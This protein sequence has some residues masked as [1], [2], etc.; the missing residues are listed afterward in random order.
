MIIKNSYRFWLVLV[1]CLGATGLQAQNLALARHYLK[2]AQY[3]KALAIY[4]DWYDNQGY[5]PEVYRGLLKIYLQK[6]RFDDAEKL[7]KD[8]SGRYAVPEAEV[9]LFYVYQKA[10]KT[11]AARQ[12]W[13][14]IIEKVK[15]Q[16]AYALIYARRLRAYGYTD[17]A[18]QLLRNE[19]KRKPSPGLYLEMGNLY[20]EKFLPD[21]MMRAYVRAA[22]MH[23]GYAS[24]IQSALSRY[25]DAKPDNPYAVALK[26]VLLEKIAQNPA[27]AYFQLLLWLYTRQQQYD[28]AFVQAKGLYLRGLLRPVDLYHLA[29][30]ARRQGDNSTALTIVDF[31][32]QSKEKIPRLLAEQLQVL[33]A[34]I[35][36]G[37][38]GR[39]NLDDFVGRWKAVADTLQYDQT[40]F[41]LYRLLS[42]LLIENE[43][44]DTAYHWADSLAKTQAPIRQQAFWQ[45][46]KG[47][48]L[49][50][51]GQFA[52]AA[53]VFTLLRE[54]FRYDEVNYRAL[55]KMALASFL[56]G[57]ADWAHRN[58]KP[59]KKAA[60]R[61]IANDALM[62]DFMI[63]ANR[64]PADSLQ[65]GLQNLAQ[66]YYYYYTGKRSAL[67]RTA[68]SLRGLA[69]SKK[70]A[71]DLLYLEAKAETQ[72]GNTSA[73]INYWEKLLS[74]TKEKMFRQE[75]LYR[76]GILLRDAGQT[77]K[78][79]KILLEVIRDY[80]E[81]FYFEPAQKAYRELT[82]Q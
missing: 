71:D 36:S 20:A 53:I 77:E 13:K 49:L 33:R 10:G 35:L 47:D 8:A 80:P 31:L 52:R 68:D 26:R 37:K 11:D 3:D 51:Q 73:A 23:T 48:V 17:K 5:R 24:Y 57:D 58:L 2:A 6:G 29:L 70:I 46:R 18:L 45:E 55:Y 82:G 25:I 38:T 74:T 1:L 40:R 60:S 39:E 62:L 16:P 21:S 4:R 59:L 28:K 78:A 50:R 19:E 22:E 76:L 54:N 61:E 41:E 64:N 34:Q 69:T 79:K 44:L 67:H 42:D 30:S 27:P 15:H 72:A 14:T 12:Q 43:R 7:I 63:I 75:A 32:Q 56:D 65:R 81:G 66:A 9:D